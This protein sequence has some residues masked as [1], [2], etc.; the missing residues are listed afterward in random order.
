MLRFEPQYHLKPWGGR[1]MAQH[2]SRT[3]PEGQV[4][5][6]WELVELPGHENVVAEGPKKGEKLGDL[7]RSGAL[8]G[9]ANGPFPFFLKWL[10]THERMSVQVHP[11]EEF[12]QNTRLGSPKTEAWYIAHAE[13][14]SKFLAGNYPGLDATTLKQAVERGSLEKWMYEAAPRPGDMYL[15]QAG[16]IHA[17]G[18]G[19]LALEVQEPSETTFRVHDW[20]RVNEAGESRELHLDEAAACIRYNRFDLPQPERAKVTG[21][22]FV[23]ETVQMGVA[24]PKDG[25]RVVIADKKPVKLIGDSG[26]EHLKFGDVVVIEPS[27]GIVALASGSCVLLT[28]PK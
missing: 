9:S 11:D 28:E 27:D 20:N 17:M 16:T 15:I 1:R 5:E 12:C 22:C 25:L 4:G 18:A 8:G 21:P 19:F 13:H 3:L 14:K 24:F 26:E 7:W 2:F 23:M 10:D 6:S